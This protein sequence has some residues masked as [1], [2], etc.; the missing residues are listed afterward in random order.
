MDELKNVDPATYARLNVYRSQFVTRISPDRLTE[1]GRI[2]ETYRKMSRPW[3]SNDSADPWLVGSARLEG[4]TIVTDELPKG[5]RM[6]TVCE[7]EGIPWMD[8]EGL[9]EAE[10]PGE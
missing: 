1:A 2:N 7:K 3:H 10:P 9:V 8:L 6:P 4:Y 5:G